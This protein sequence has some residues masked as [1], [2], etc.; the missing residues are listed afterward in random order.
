MRPARSN[1]GSE[2][3][4]SQ[5]GIDRAGRGHSPAR[6]TA[7]VFVDVGDDGF[8]PQFS[9]QGNLFFRPLATTPEVRSD[10]EGIELD[11]VPADADAEA[12]PTT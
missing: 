11:P 3:P 2:K 1:A 12:Q 10:L 6:S 5:I 4:P 9:H 8:G 7:V